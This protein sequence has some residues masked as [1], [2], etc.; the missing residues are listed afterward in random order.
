MALVPGVSAAV[1]AG[2]PGERTRSISIKLRK[3]VARLVTVDVEL[4]LF[5]SVSVPGLVGG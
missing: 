5:L 1:L 2:V 4:L 3:S